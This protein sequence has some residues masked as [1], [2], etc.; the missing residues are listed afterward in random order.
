MKCL[1]H[2]WLRRGHTVIG[3]DFYGHTLATAGR[4]SGQNV[5][6]KAGPFI[7]VNKQL[8]QADIGPLDL[9]MIKKDFVELSHIVRQKWQTGRTYRE[10]QLFLSILHNNTFNTTKCILW[11]PSPLLKQLSL[12]SNIA[13]AAATTVCLSFL[14]G[15]EREIIWVKRVPIKGESVEFF[16][17]F[18]APSRQAVAMYVAKVV[19]HFLSFLFFRQYEIKVLEVF[20]FSHTHLVSLSS[21]TMIINML[22]LCSYSSFC[23]DATATLLLPLDEIKWSR[24]GSTFH[25]YVEDQ[26]TPLSPCISFSFSTWL[27]PKFFSNR[28]LGG[29]NDFSACIHM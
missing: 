28:K 29:R 7:F 2:G 5:I 6:L 21:V 24:K 13:A 10:L 16:C 15:L 23:S 12:S 14:M 27:N 18:H 11:L 1:F 4:M 9:W 8:S 17:N 26:L 25:M 20:S 19:M 22:H 3:L